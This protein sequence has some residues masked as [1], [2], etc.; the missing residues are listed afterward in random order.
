MAAGGAHQTQQIAF[1]TPKTKLAVPAGGCPMIM[2]H[3]PVARL[4]LAGLTPV[5]L[6]RIA[7]KTHNLANEVISGRGTAKPSRVA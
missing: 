3:N 6:G 5:T 1:A 7:F 4:Q 2:Q